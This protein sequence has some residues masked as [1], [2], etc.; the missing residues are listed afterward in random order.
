M[1]DDL[2]SREEALE[3]LRLLKRFNTTEAMQIAIDVAEQQINF[4]RIAFDKKK[5][6]EELENY[7]F[8][9]YCVEGDDKTADIVEKGGI[10]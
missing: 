2:I 5:V 8:E 3:R 10:E 4:C 1:N 7:L 9:K 6:K